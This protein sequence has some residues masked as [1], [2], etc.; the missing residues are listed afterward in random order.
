MPAKIRAIPILLISYSKV[1]PMMRFKPKSGNQ[2]EENI[3]WITM[4]DLMLGLVLVFMILFFYSST[5]NYFE[6]VREQAVTGNINEQLAEKLKAQNIDASIDLFS[7]VVKISDLE[8][9]NVNSWELSD[10]GKAYLDKFIPVYIE[11]I[12]A[13]DEYKGK[14]TGLIIQG[15]T[16]S[17]TFAGLD[18]EEA[19][20]MKNMELSLKRA[21]SVA[22]YIPNTNYDKKYFKDLEKI[23]FVEGCSYNNP[24]LDENGKEDYDKSRRVELKLV[25]KSD[26]ANSILKSL[27]KDKG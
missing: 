11:T 26:S 14:I 5:S 22:S 16:D 21:Y 19:Q 24:V 25:T 9:F 2:N 8:L 10:K 15:H 18:T 17:Q 1:L 27:G 12:L 20:Y 6:K 7:G 4:T 3:F 13:N 23:L